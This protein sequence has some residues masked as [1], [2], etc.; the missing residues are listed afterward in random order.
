M[1]PHRLVELEDMVIVETVEHLPPTL[2]VADEAGVSQCPQLMGNSGLRN[3]KTLRQVAHAALGTG[4]EGDQAQSGGIGEDT[5]E[6]GGEKALFILGW[7][8]NPQSQT[9]HEHLLFLEALHAYLVMNAPKRDGGEG[10]RRMQSRVP[11]PGRDVRR[12]AE[13]AGTNE[14]L[15]RLYSPTENIAVIRVSSPPV[16]ASAGQLSRRS[17]ESANFVKT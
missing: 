7:E 2:S 1:L 16:L 3:R 9:R 6:L 8:D 12:L 11:A 4:E 17:F 13:S 10:G 5:E 14:H 15:V